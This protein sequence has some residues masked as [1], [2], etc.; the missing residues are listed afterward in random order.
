ML[1]L[2][3]VATNMAWVCFYDFW[4]STLYKYVCVVILMCQWQCSLHRCL[5]WRCAWC[6]VNNFFCFD[7][8]KECQGCRAV[9]FTHEH[10]LCMTVKQ[11]V[12]IPLTFVF[13]WGVMSSSVG[14]AMKCNPCKLYIIRVW[15]SFICS[16]Y[17]KEVTKKNTSKNYVWKMFFPKMLFSRLKVFW[18]D[19]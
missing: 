1:W 9:R 2:L 8:G 19:T 14:S 12:E 15:Q 13:L 11:F 16:S 3:S 4:F 17:M 10:K 6:V 5:V 7:C 18:D